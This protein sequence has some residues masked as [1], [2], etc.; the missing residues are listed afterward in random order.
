MLSQTDFNLHHNFL[1]SRHTVYRAPVEYVAESSQKV[2]RRE[3]KTGASVIGTGFIVCF[4]LS[5]INAAECLPI[6][7]RW[8]GGNFS[9]NAHPKITIV[10][11][12]LRPSR[13]EAEPSTR[14][15]V[16]CKHFDKNGSINIYLQIVPRPEG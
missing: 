14:P 5:V 2:Q 13:T 12:S 15:T 9:S 6:R 3:S 11:E 1:S 7:S 4:K 8:L 10:H 16:D